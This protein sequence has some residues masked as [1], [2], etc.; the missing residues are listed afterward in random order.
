MSKIGFFIS[1]TR[2]HFFISKQRKVAVN[3]G[4]R[5]FELVINSGIR[6]NSVH[7]I[8]ERTFKLKDAIDLYQSYHRQTAEDP[9]DD[10]VLTADDWQELSLLRQLLA[11]MKKMSLLLQSDFSQLAYGSL[12]QLL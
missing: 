3:E 5:L 8:L 12:Y 11:P 9:L 2:R 7:D 4:L 10:D 1:D 6:W